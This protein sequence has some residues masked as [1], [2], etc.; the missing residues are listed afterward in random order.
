MGRIVESKKGDCA[1]KELSQPPMYTPV[2]LYNIRL[3]PIRDRFYIP[4]SAIKGFVLGYCIT[5]ISHD[6]SG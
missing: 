4:A 3:V 1:G 5:H 6:G 2:D